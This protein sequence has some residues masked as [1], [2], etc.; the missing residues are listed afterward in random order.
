MCCTISL[1]K[2]VA[3]GEAIGLSS[4]FSYNP[5]TIAK[6]VEESSEKLG[7]TREKFIEVAMRKSSLFTNDPDTM[8]NNFKVLESLF[9]MTNEDI[10]KKN[11]A[12][13]LLTELLCFSQNLEKATPETLEIAAFLMKKGAE[14]GEIAKKLFAIENN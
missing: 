12:E 1:A 13:C 10:I 14:R 3:C 7:L 8:G 9:K 5:K 2:K 4:I 6:N 11:A